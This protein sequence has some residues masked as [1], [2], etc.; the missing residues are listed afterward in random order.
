MKTLKT[1]ITNSF[2]VMSMFF[3]FI[4]CKK[5][6]AKPVDEAVA[7]EEFTMNGTATSQYWIMPNNTGPSPDNDQAKAFILNSYDPN[8]PFIYSISIKIEK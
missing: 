2:L 8:K 4:A 3:V 1:N 6:K 7:L 5:D